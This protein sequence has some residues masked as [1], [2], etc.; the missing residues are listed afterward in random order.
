MDALVP[1][2]RLCPSVL[3]LVEAAQIVDRDGGLGRQIP[4]TQQNV[5]RSLPVLPVDVHESERKEDVGVIGVLPRHVLIEAIGLGQAA[6]LE[7]ERRQILASE[8]GLGVAGGE[9][10]NA[11]QGGCRALNGLQGFGETDGGVLP[12]RADAEGLLQPGDGVF[13]SFF[14]E[15]DAPERVIGGRGF[16]VFVGQCAQ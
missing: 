10:L 1:L 8:S 15:I 2:Q 14:K 9:A 3:C 7:I 11:A 6:H 4:G 13:R 5:F 12:V 16:R